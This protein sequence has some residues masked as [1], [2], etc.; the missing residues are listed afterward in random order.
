MTSSPRE[1]AAEQGRSTKKGGGMKAS[2]D[3]VKW[4]GT[5]ALLLGLTGCSASPPDQFKPISEQKKAQL[6]R[7]LASKQSQLMGYKATVTEQTDVD[8]RSETSH[9]G[10]IEFF[11]PVTKAVGEHESQ[12]VDTV[13]AEYG[14]SARDKKWA[15]KGCGLKQSGTFPME[16]KERLVTFREVVD[17]FEK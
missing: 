9:I 2:R 3:K 6:T 4:I 13:V 15:Y 1:P 12:G 5:V 11:Y 10:V 8:R 16:E 14:F 17:A 7:F